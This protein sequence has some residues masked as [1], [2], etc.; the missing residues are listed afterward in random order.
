MEDRLADRLV[1]CWAFRASWIM[2]D[3]LHSVFLLVFVQV[4]RTCRKARRHWS[5]LLYPISSPGKTSFTRG[6]WNYTPFLN[7]Q[8]EI[9]KKMYCTKYKAYLFDKK[10]LRTKKKGCVLK[11]GDYCSW[12]LQWTEFVLALWTPQPPS[13]SCQCQSLCRRKHS[14]KVCLLLV[15]KTLACSPSFENLFFLGILLPW[16]PVGKTLRVFKEILCNKRPRSS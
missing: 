11:L 6:A 12:R 7:P 14:M 10:K 1:L 4:Q 3:L 16:P 5:A 15:P 2:N 8:P 9:W 13:R